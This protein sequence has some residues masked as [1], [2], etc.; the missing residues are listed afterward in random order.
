LALIWRPK[1][2]DT[3]VCVLEWHA[4]EA[5]IG[6]LELGV[7][8]DNL[9][10]LAKTGDKIGIDVPF[11]WPVAFVQAVTAHQAGQPWPPA[12]RQSLRLRET[13]IRVESSR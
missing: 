10:G 2:K 5:I 12:P 3:A 8:D 7:T 11:G 4:T 9:L 1:P 13:D 6:N